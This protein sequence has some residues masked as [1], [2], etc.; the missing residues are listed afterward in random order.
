M[1]LLD[2][3]KILS[4]VIAAITVFIAYRQYTLARNKMKLD[5][6]EKRFKI[7]Q[8][9]HKLIDRIVGGSTLSDELFSDFV[10]A[11]NESFF[12]F[13][14]K[15][16]KQIDEFYTVG[17]NYR[18]YMSF[19]NGTVFTT[20]E[21]DEEL[22]RILAID[23]DQDKLDKVRLKSFFHKYGKTHFWSLKDLFFK[24]LNFKKLS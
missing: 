5:L 14:K 7:F 3:I 6:Y 2:S 20:S 17:F 1:E 4:A 18:Y 9:T 19:E 24:Y 10:M 22:V 15:L 13:D 21:I 16:Y 12:L 8:V 23:T 11:R